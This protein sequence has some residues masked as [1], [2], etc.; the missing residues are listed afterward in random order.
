MNNEIKFRR[1]G[2]RIVPIREGGTKENKPIHAGKVYASGVAITV[3]SQLGAV[4]YNKKVARK[5]DTLDQFRSEARALMRKHNGLRRSAGRP[6]VAPGPVS[7]IVFG[8]LK[9]RSK[10]KIYLNTMDESTV[11]HELSHAVA[12]RKKGSA[13]RWV[14]GVGAQA[15]RGKISPLKAGIFKA[16][17]PF[18][19]IPIELEAHAIGFKYMHKVGGIKAVVK[20]IRS[21]GPGFGTYLGVALGS[22]LTNAGI[23][24]AIKHQVDKFRR[25]KNEH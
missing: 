11:I 8:H 7:G 5:F 21:L 3:A 16:T 18:T 10:P 20:G 9:P 17:R 24:I 6:S 1:I 13:N 12:S 25:K 22:A 4:A 14:R 2:G 23:G 15:V 19:S